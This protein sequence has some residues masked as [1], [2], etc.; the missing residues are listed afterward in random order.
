M[1]VFRDVDDRQIK[2]PTVL[3]FG[4]F[5]G[6]HLA[7]R[8]IMNRVIARARASKLPATVVTFDPH[9]R[10]VLRPQTAPPLLQTFEQKMEGMER[11]GIEQ[12]VVLNFTP[13][14]AR[15]AA[16]DFLNNIIFGR[17]DAREVYLGQGF[18]FGHGRE[19][20]FELLRQVAGARGRV[21]EEVP[22]V[23]IRGHRVSSTMIRRLLSAGRVNLA[24][25]MLGRPYGIESRVIEGRRIAKAQLNYPTA[26]LKPHNTVIPTNG[27]YIT[28][29]LVEG[30][31]LRSITNIGNKPTFGGDPEVTIETHLMDFDRELY[32]EKIRVRFLYRLRG[33]RKF[34]SVDALRAQID[35]DYGRAVRYFGMG[36]VRH[37]FEFR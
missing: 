36:L 15:V 18:A 14:L 28:L 5:D 34:K 17:L 9:P 23:V 22:E 25:R 33:E 8:Q 37:N 31:W 6:L 1:K 13:E 3:T 26:N 21:A 29:T 12:V 7:H 35:R 11:L 30:E 20:K 27:V 24:R 16:E 2:T 32:G 4:V 19:G 10:A